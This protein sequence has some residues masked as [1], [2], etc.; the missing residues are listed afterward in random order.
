MIRAVLTNGLVKR[1][2]VV[3][4]N[5]GLN[6]VDRVEDEPAAGADGTVLRSAGSIAGKLG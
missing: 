5:A 2:Q 1:E 3:C 6:I 4:R